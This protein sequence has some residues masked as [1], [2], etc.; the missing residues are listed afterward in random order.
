LEL[1]DLSVE[2]QI[3]RQILD[4]ELHISQQLSRID[5]SRWRV[6][7]YDR[8]I[9]NPNEVARVAGSLMN[10]GAENMSPVKN[11]VALSSSE[12]VSDILD[13]MVTKIVLD[14]EYWK[15]LYSEVDNV[16]RD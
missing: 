5:S 11:I 8:M 15:Q 3:A 7:D 9:T 14:N 12:K 1:R 6:V 10:M 4:I 16:S 13:D 2:E